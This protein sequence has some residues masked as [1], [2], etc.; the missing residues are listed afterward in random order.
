MFFVSVVTRIVPVMPQAGVRKKV[1]AYARV[2]DDGDRLLNSLSNQVSYYNEYIQANPGWEFAGVYVD[3]AISGTS[4]KNRS[5]LNNLLHLARK[6][7]VDMVL[8]KSISRMARNTVDL[9][10]IVRELKQLNVVVRFERENI[11]TSTVDGELLLTLLASFAQEESRSLS[12][13]VK[14]GIRNRFKQGISNSNVLYGYRWDKTAKTLRIHAVEAEAVRLMYQWF[15]SGLAAEQIATRLNTQGYKSY[16][17]K[18]L[19]GKRVMAVLE[20]E[21]YTGCQ[22]LQKTYLPTIGSNRQ[23]LNDGVLPKYWVE[24]VNPAIISKT[25]YEQVQAEIKQRRSLGKAGIPSLNSSGFTSR[26]RCGV[27]GKHYHRKSRPQKSGGKKW[28]WRCHSACQGT[29]N[30]CKASNI[31]EKYLKQLVCKTLN[32][33]KFADSL[34]LENIKCFTVYP[35]RI[36]IVKTSGQKIV[37]SLSK[38]MGVK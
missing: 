37:T 21:R 25:L 33:E 16:M 1:A 14:W 31:D 3:E 12:E 8:C 13:N 35:N 36:E 34:I 26:I 15:L 9:L 20:N 27:C 24:D 29:G 5:G 19:C 30:P 28:F 18:K 10:S 38:F 32:S 23:N 7:Q 2:S 22:M 4:M 6:G 11:D 17:G